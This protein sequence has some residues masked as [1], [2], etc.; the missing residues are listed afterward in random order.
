MQDNS[1]RGER[2]V[3]WLKAVFVVTVLFAL[4]LIPLYLNGIESLANTGDL[5]QV[6][7]AGEMMLSVLQSLFALLALAV[8]FCVLSIF[9]AMWL[10]R[11]E[12]NL[13]RFAKTSFSPW[14]AVFCTLFFSF[15]PIAGSILD[16]LIFRELLN[17]YERVLS[18]KGVEYVPSGRRALNAVLVLSL[19]SE[20]LCFFSFTACDVA[21]GI[22]G[23]ATIVAAIRLVRDVMAYE[24]PL[25]AFD[26]DTVLRRKVDEV[27][28]E[29]EIEKAAAE[30]REATYG[31]DAV[32]PADKTDR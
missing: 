15:I 8:V 11:S 9:W 13:R 31:S 6:P 26:Q 24:K 30:V 10:Y 1:T 14:G 29:R 21:G 23:L 12:E 22:A 18:A 25:F 4:S 19:L 5:S 28:R 3:F 2:T 16:Y 27:L 20:I 17:G 32:P 7:E